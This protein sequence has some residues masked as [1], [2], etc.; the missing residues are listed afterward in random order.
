MLYNKFKASLGYMRL[1][2]NKIKQNNEMLME[3]VG[4]V[5][6]AYSLSTQKAE[7]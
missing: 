2:V 1:Y 4:V 3:E 6:R 5:V 7:A